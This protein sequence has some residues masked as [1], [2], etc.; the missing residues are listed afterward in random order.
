[1]E[2]AMSE[3][4]YGLQPRNVR[5]ISTPYRRIVTKIP[6]P[7]SIGIL[8]RL[9]KYEPR[10]MSGQPPI[11]WDRAEGFQVYDKY[12]N[13]WLDWSSGVHSPIPQHPLYDLDFI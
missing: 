11:M 2:E 12:G 4:T 3:Q 8:K 7:E 1:M 9:R 13:M 6:V 5:R 10:S